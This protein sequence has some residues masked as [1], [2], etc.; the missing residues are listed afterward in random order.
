MTPTVANSSVYASDSGDNA[1][2]RDSGGGSVSGG[3][4][5]YNSDDDDECATPQLSSPPRAELMLSKDRDMSDFVV[6]ASAELFRRRL[7]EAE[8]EDAAREAA[9]S[10]MADGPLEL[11][12][13]EEYSRVRVVGERGGKYPHNVFTCARPLC[14]TVVAELGRRIGSLSVGGD[15]YPR[16]WLRMVPRER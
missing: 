10:A 12:S 15:L 4:G 11:V 1:D 16:L 9:T 7:E 13:E 14:L 6:P 8:A 3:R 2:R 5:V